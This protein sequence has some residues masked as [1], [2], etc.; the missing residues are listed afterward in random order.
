VLDAAA[1][2]SQKQQAQHNAHVAALLNQP[3]FTYRLGVNVRNVF[4]IK[5]LR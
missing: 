5:I 3:V 4:I 2:L 1:H